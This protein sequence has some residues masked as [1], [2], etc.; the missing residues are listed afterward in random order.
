MNAV[1]VLVWLHKR[2]R[3]YRRDVN[4]KMN[5]IEINWGVMNSIRLVKDRKKWLASGNSLGLL[6]FVCLYC[7]EFLS[8]LRKSQFLKKVCAPGV[9]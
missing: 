5:P 8:M 9:S 4:I 1:R 3:R 6:Y 7:E 2:Q